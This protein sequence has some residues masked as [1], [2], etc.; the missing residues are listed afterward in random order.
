FATGLLFIALARPYLFYDWTDER[1]SGV[2]VLLAVDCS[3]SMLTQD[4]LPNRLERAKLA[5]SDFAAQLPADRLGL[6]AFAGDAFLQC[7][8][9]LD[10]D[11]FLD[12]LRDLDTDSIPR[13]GTDI[14]TAIDEAADALRSQPNNMKFL[15]LVTDG[16]DLEGRA[17]DAAHKAAQGGLR[18]FTV[19]VGTPEGDRI[20]ENGDSGYLTYHHDLDGNEVI[21]RLDENTLRKI[22]DITG[23][24]YAPLGPQGDGLT[25]IYDRYIASL[26]KQSLEEKRQKIHIERFEW[27]LAAAILFLMWEFLIGERARASKAEAPPSAARRRS[28]AKDVATSTAVICALLSGTPSHASDLS[29]AQQAYQKGDYDTSMQSYGKAA[30]AYPTRPELQFDRGDAAY[31]AGE[32]S[33]AEEAF[34]KA[35][36]TPNLNVQEQSYYNLGNTQYEHG[37]ALVKADRDRTIELWK[38]A[39]HSYQNALQLKPAPDTQHNYDVV[40]RKLDEL[41]KEQRG[42]NQGQSGSGQGQSGSGAQQSGQAGSSSSSGNGGTSGNQDNSGGTSNNNSAGAGEKNQQP[43]SNPG[44]SGNPNLQA[45][46]GTRGRDQQDPQIRSRQD[47]E[48]LLDSLQGEERHITARSYSSN[49][50]AEPPPSGKD[51]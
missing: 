51:W 12:S 13:P 33:E 23:G 5:I 45:Y 19:G 30:Q 18:I 21:S 4:V 9:T 8:L 36:E 14:A 3:K 46:S 26:P 40:K 43:G 42:G 48:N 11:A 28:T 44:I 50:T 6:I 29:Q 25:Q 15:I 17:L 27:P 34:R 41:M 20:P 39:L 7:P 10:H 16:E 24:S 49:G 47:A 1:R 22:A 35:L 31:K 38:A 32:Y 2:D 37:A